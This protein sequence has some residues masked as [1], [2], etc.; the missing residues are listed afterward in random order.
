M[1]AIPKKSL[2][3]QDGRKSYLLESLSSDTEEYLYKG[4]S[5]KIKDITLTQN[6]KEVR[7]FIYENY[8][9]HKKALQAAAQ[10]EFSS[11]YKALQNIKIEAYKRPFYLPYPQ[12]RVNVSGYL[13]VNKE[14]SKEMDIIYLLEEDSC[15]R[16]TTIFPDD[17]MVTDEEVRDNVSNADDVVIDIF[18]SFRENINLDTLNE[19]NQKKYSILISSGSTSSK[20]DLGIRYSAMEPQWKGGRL[21]QDRNLYLDKLVPQPLTPQDLKLLK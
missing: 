16:Y 21:R 18:K 9:D 7:D 10:Y 19:V 6:A 11:I 3:Y 15:E 1:S 20:Y 17:C 5:K 8:K 12:G 4:N 2:F 13:L 14:Y